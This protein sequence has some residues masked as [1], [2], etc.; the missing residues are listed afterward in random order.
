MNMRTVI[1]VAMGTY[2][3]SLSMGFLVLTLL[4]D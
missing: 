4:G 3:L 2:G 1:Y